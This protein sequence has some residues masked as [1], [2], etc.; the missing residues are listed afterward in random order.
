MKEKLLNRLSQIK[1]VGNQTLATKH[2]TEWAECVDTGKMNGF[3]SASLSFIERI[4]GKNHSYYDSFL[5]AVKDS[6]PS[7][8]E[9]GLQILSAIENEISSDWL[10]TVKE[11]VVSEVF[12]D[13]MEMASHLIELKYKDPAAVIIGSVLEEHLRQLCNSNSISIEFEKDGKQIPKKAES[14]NTELTRNKIYSK[15]DQKNVTAWL[16][17]RNKA[18]HGHYNEYNIDQVKN[19]HLNVLEFM[20]RGLRANC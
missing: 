8:I 9:S 12:A 2:S 6:D 14:L 20:A 15:L 16:D 13:F 17:L 11:L 1:E 5:S 19:L 18:A 4:Y 7:D 10:F 3:K